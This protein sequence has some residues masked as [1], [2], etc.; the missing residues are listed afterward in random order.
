MNPYDLV[1][2]P[3]YAIPQSYPDKLAVVAT[4]FG[5]TPAPPGR[6]RILDVGCSTGANLM[7]MALLW[8]ES[9]YVGIDLAAAPI[10]KAKEHAKH[11]G[12]TNVRFE[13]ADLMD[14]P[15]DF[16]QFDYIIAHGFISWVPTFV[17]KRLFEVCRERLAPQGIAYISYN[18]YPGCHVRDMF[19]QIMKE[20]TREISDPVERAREG[21]SIVQ[22]IA[23]CG[24]A[25]DALQE[26]A[27]FERDIICKK[28]IGALFHDELEVHFNSL[29]F[30]EFAKLAEQHDLQF[31]FEAVYNE[32]QPPLQLTGDAVQLVEQA[33]ARGFLVREQYLDFLKL[34]RFR[35]CL[36]THSSVAIDRDHPLRAMH[37][38]HYAA[39]LTRTALAEGV[40]FSNPG[41]NAAVVT[42]NP[43]AITAL[44][45]IAKAWP[46][47]IA[48]DELL[49][50][51]LE[52]E[53]LS[54]PLERFL[55][56]GLI[57][58]HAT[59]RECQQQPGS[60]PEVWSYARHQAESERVLT[61]LTLTGV[62]VEDPNIRKL[63]LLADGTRTV[64][65]LASALGDRAGV[66]RALTG[67]A[68]MGFL[69][70]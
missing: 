37:Q 2:Y 56:A 58:A 5:M 62:A 8:P 4:M 52:R 51:P 15:A 55:A 61:P 54:A 66:E 24:L 13:A 45:R 26:L 59:P 7:P 32:G 20:H 44:D 43:V 14:L 22:T 42:P 65:E 3:S 38:F 25:A 60:H 49:D 69:V 1:E 70:R 27:R 39:P 16:G 18:A 67:A 29:Y 31:I 50:D 10:A 63:V 9:E 46:S 48:F 34:R 36:V 19:R 68:R 21:R 41:T 53:G 40:E 64:E 23:E 57:D 6:A 33:S 47:T 11:L 12:L 30:H 35:Q 17:R 28:S